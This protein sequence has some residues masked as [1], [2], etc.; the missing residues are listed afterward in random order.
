MFKERLVPIRKAG[1]VLVGLGVLLIGGGRQSIGHLLFL[2]ADCLWAGYAFAMRRVR[3]NGLHAA[4][5]SMMVYLPC[6]LTFSERRL[7]EVASTDLFGQ[8]FYQGVVTATVSLALFGRSIV[9]LG[10]SKAAAF[11][12]LTPVMAALMAIPAL[13]EWPTAIDWLAIVIITAGVYLASGAPAPGSTAE[14]PLPTGRGLSPARCQAEPSAF[15][16]PRLRP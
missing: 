11:V 12:A 14:I 4:V 1:L 13:G 8:A 15:R 10:T 3:L 16:R 5:V 2:A 7:L 9:L 6:Y